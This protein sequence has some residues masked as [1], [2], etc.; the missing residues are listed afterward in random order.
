MQKSTFTGRYLKLNPG[1]PIP[2]SGSLYFK[3]RAVYTLPLLIPLGL[4]PL[5]R[6]RYAAYSLTFSVGVTYLP[7]L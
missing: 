1:T 4:P 3:R 2:I 6:T 5:V 7:T